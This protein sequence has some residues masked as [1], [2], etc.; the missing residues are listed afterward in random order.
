LGIVCLA[1]LRWW[2]EYSSNMSGVVEYLHQDHMGSTRLKTNATGGIVYESNYEPH[3]PGS[4]ETGSEDYRY[5]GKREDP[6]GDELSDNVNYPSLFF[7][8]VN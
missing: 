1:C 7:N 8:A 4:G 2:I 6:T 5:M 3:G